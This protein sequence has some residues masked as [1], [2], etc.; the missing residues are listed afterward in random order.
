ME[1]LISFVRSLN[2]IKLDS[3][4]LFNHRTY[5]LYIGHYASD[6]IGWDKVCKNSIQY[7]VTKHRQNLVQLQNGAGDSEQSLELVAKC[8][9]RVR[10]SLPMFLN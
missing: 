5:T 1:N 9:G 3:T 10:L 6:L 2:N 4:A 7:V 8:S